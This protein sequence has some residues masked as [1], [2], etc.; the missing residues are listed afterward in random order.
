MNQIHPE[1]VLVVGWGGWGTSRDCFQERERPK[2]GTFGA[3][4]RRKMQQGRE[5]FEEEECNEPNRQIH[6]GNVLVVFMCGAARS[7]QRH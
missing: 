2:R 1:N 6:P 5:E 3:Q 7:L 4:D